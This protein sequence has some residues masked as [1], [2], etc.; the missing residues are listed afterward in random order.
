[1]MEAITASVLHED[2]PPN[3]FTR[4]QSP[5]P[6]LVG[7]WAGCWG[8]GW[9]PAPPKNDG[10]DSG[11]CSPR[12]LAAQ[13]LHSPPIAAPQAGVSVSRLRVRFGSTGMPGPMVVVKVTFFRYR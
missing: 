10:S 6:R 9:G 5:R 13:S 2:S 3:R 1:M 4:R 8:G 11:E 7:R 12:A